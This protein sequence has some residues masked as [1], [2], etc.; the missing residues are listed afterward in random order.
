MRCAR[1]L[2]QL[3]NTPLKDVYRQYSWEEKMQQVLPIQRSNM[4]FSFLV[5]PFSPDRAVPSYNDL[6][7]TVV[8]AMSWLSASQTSGVPINFLNIQTEPILT[9]VPGQQAS[10]CTVSQEDLSSIINTG[11]YGFEDYHGIDIGVV[12]AVRLW[13]VPTVGEIT[14]VLNPEEGETRLGVGISRTDE[15]F[16]YVSSV[17]NGTVADKAG[18]KTL[19]Q[20]ARSAGIKLVIS[21]V[22]EEKITPSMVSSSGSIRCFDTLSISHKLV[23]H[24]QAG[25]PVK[26]QLM[27]WDGAML[28]REWGAA[29]VHENRMTTIKSQD[30]KITTNH[31]I[32]TSEK[33]NQ[34]HFSDPFENYLRSPYDLCSEK[35]DLDDT[36]FEFDKVPSAAIDRDST[37]E[38]SFRL[39]N[40]DI[41][42]CHFEKYW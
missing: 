37:G 8:R 18:L 4:V 19:Y 41:P 31:C 25:Q 26:I 33:R 29:G 35:H 15:G 39:S 36:S 20:E 21:R 40:F 13:Y 27:V 16:C 32:N 28:A 14:I 9:K 11:I 10:S 3:A 24:R 1:L 42:T 17:E 12:R 38:F 30:N 7:D 6:D 22:G 23:L 34:R 5:V 2:N